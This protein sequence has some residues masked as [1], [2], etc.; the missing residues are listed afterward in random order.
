MQ[1]FYLDA[2][3]KIR[4]ENST[5]INELSESRGTIQKPLRKKTLEGRN[6]QVTERRKSSAIRSQHNLKRNESSNKYSDH[7]L[8]E[9]QRRYSP[10]FQQYV[11][12]EFTS[13][14]RHRRSR[15]S[16]ADILLEE[17]KEVQ[18]KFSYI[19]KKEN[20]LKRIRKLP[21]LDVH[22]DYVS[23]SS[24]STAD[25]VYTTEYQ[26]QYKDPKI[27]IEKMKKRMTRLEKFLEKIE[28]STYAQ[29]EHEPEVAKQF[30]FTSPV[31]RHEEEIKKINDRFKTEYMREYI[32]YYEEY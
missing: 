24:H 4:G 11:P 22:D 28:S 6:Q 23:D 32:N 15:K 16:R 21:A 30:I 31:K 25:I 7:F 17:K 27:L 20:I 26:R 9:Y 19:Q 8:T 18:K 5:Y 12:P 29:P 2:K 10:E 3:K 14:P 1:S 13:S